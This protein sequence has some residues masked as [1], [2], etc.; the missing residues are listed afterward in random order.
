VERAAILLVSALGLAACKAKQE[1]ASTAPSASVDDAPSR[2]PDRVVSGDGYVFG[3]PDKDGLAVGLRVE[4]TKLARNEVVR[5]WIA[6]QNRGRSVVKRRLFDDND[7]VYPRMKLVALRADGAR[8]TAGRAVGWNEP[9]SAGFG[10]DVT[11]G[12]NETRERQGNLF[13]LPSNVEGKV[14]LAIVFGGSPYAFELES[15]RVDVDVAAA[16]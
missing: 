7:F 13:A 15:G 6:L 3:A 10:I 2:A 11:V 4:K 14:S 5:Y 9:S 16:P 12:P 8:V 1:E